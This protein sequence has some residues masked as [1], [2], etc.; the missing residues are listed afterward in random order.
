MLFDTL[1]SA[2]GRCGKDTP[3]AN[4]DYDMA[5]RFLRNINLIVDKGESP[6]ALLAR[7]IIDNVSGALKT[8]FTITIPSLSQQH[9]PFTTTSTT[10][11]PINTPPQTIDVPR[12]SCFLFRRVSELLRIR[13]IVFS[14]RKR[15]QFYDNSDLTN[16]YAS[17]VVL[18]HVKSSYEGVGQFVAL[19]AAPPSPCATDLKSAEQGKQS[20]ADQFRPLSVGYT[21]SPTFV[22]SD[23]SSSGQ[24]G[25]TISHH[26]ELHSPSQDEHLYMDASPSHSPSDSTP[27]YHIATFRRN[28]RSRKRLTK[29]EGEKLKTTIDP[30]A[31]Y[32]VFRQTWYVSG[33]LK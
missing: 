19:K 3:I 8:Q 13:I 18:L 20:A 10:T 33:T 29:K 25:H 12:K 9:I 11:D 27:I 5:L 31:S 1:L 28:R 7:Y 32:K 4:E 15:T 21:S 2:Q 17:T 23:P 26:T 22:Q 24:G 16:P 14:T 6:T 30:E